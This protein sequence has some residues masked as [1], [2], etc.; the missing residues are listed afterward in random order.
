MNSECRPFS[1]LGIIFSQ[2]SDLWFL[3]LLVDFYRAVR[4][5]FV[6][7]KSWLWRC[8]TLMHRDVAFVCVDLALVANDRRPC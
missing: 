2:S 8:V 1:F 6:L 5:P 3:V 4:S 7:H